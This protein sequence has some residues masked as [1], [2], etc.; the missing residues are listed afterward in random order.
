M[1]SAWFTALHR[2][3]HRAAG[4][5]VFETYSRHDLDYIRGRCTCGGTVRV[6]VDS[7]HGLDVIESS[8]P[9]FVRAEIPKAKVVP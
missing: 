9:R 7:T 8:C 1:I 4:H 3:W 5:Y 2:L 6:H